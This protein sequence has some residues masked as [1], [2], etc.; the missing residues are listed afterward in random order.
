MPDAPEAI[1]RI[2]KLSSLHDRHGFDCGI[3]ELNLFLLRLADQ[4]QKRNL[5]QTYVALPAGQ[6]RVEGYYSLSSGAVEFDKL[7]EDQR[8]RLPRQLPIP[9]VLLGRLAVD[10]SVQG[11]GL[12]GDLLMDAM[13]R[14]QRLAEEV[15]IAAMVLN[16]FDEKA[17]QFYLRF[18]FVSLS[19]DHFHLFL[20]MK[21]IRIFFRD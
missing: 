11:R 17:R 1:W 2:E 16:A 8:R 12:G 20:S 15:G 21:E 13:H 7:S 18:G 19:G 4:H 9:V 6:K 3:P 14:S 10:R 5:A